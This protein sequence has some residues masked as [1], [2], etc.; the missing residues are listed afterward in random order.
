MIKAKNFY[1]A[2]LDKLLHNVLT[3]VDLNMSLQTYCEA[4]KKY[5]AVN[6]CG[7]A[8][9]EGNPLLQKIMVSYPKTGNERIPADINRD[10]IPWLLDADRHDNGPHLNYTHLD[11][12]HP[13]NTTVNF[14]FGK[15]LDIKNILI[16]PFQ[17]WEEVTGSILLVYQNEKRVFSKEDLQVLRNAVRQVEEAITKTMDLE[18]VK[19]SEKIITHI[20]GYLE[21]REN[22]GERNEN[23]ILEALQTVFE[24]KSVLILN[25]DK[26]RGNKYFHAVLNDKG[27]ITE[28]FSDTFEDSRYKFLTKEADLDNA[29]VIPVSIMKDDRLTGKL[30]LEYKHAD[31]VFYDSILLVLQQVAPHLVETMYH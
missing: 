27:K 21:S 25:K 2:R 22:G 1:K 17:H 20:T 10:T 31:H 4:L 19:A 15:K 23:I 30:Y 13:L 24:V 14:L 28:T 11:L 9:F 18:T 8:F 12:A 29:E 7:I 3:G 26:N 6:R 5:F 16:Y